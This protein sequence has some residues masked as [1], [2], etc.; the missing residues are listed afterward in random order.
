MDDPLEGVGKGPLSVKALARAFTDKIASPANTNSTQSLL[1]P[2]GSRD[3]STAARTVNTLNKSVESWKQGDVNSAT[4]PALP[5]S[6][7]T[8]TT[9]TTPSDF[10]DTTRKVSIVM[11]TVE[12]WG[13]DPTKVGG[14]AGP[15]PFHASHQHGSPKGASTTLTSAT[16]KLLHDSRGGTSNMATVDGGRSPPRINRVSPTP[17]FASGGGAGGGTGGVSDIQSTIQNMAIAGKAVDAWA[18][19]SSSSGPVSDHASTGLKRAT[20]VPRPPPPKPAALRPPPPPP[21]PHSNKEPLVSTTMSVSPTPAYTSELNSG[22]LGSRS[23]PSVRREPPKIPDHALKAKAK[24]VSEEPH[25]TSLETPNPSAPAAAPPPSNLPSSIDNPFSDDFHISNRSMREDSSAHEPQSTDVPRVDSVDPSNPFETYSPSDPPPITTPSAASVDQPRPINESH[26]TPM[27]RD[28]LQQRTSPKLIPTTSY[29]ST[30]GIPGRT[31]PEIGSRSPIRPPLPPRPTSPTTQSYSSNESSSP[32]SRDIPPPLPSRPSL[33][34]LLSEGRPNLPDRP[35]RTMSESYPGPHSSLLT[36]GLGKLRE[37][38]FVLDTFSK[39]NRRP[40][41]AEGIANWDILHKGG[42]VKCVAMSGFYFCTGGQQNVRVFYIPTGEN[43]RSIPLG[44]NKVTAMAFVPDR[45]IEDEGRVLWV[46]F[47]KGELMSMDISAGTVL[48]RRSAHNATVTHIIR[49]GGNLLTLDENGGFKIWYPDENGHISLSGPVRSL[50]IGSRQE[51][52]IVVNRK[53]WTA[54]GRMVEIYN[55]EETSSIFQQRIEIREAGQ[56]T[57]FAGSLDEKL[58]YSGHDDGK[59]IMWDANACVKMRVVNASIYKITAL[60]CTIQ[61]QVWVG[62]STGK[63][64]V[65]ETTPDKWT[66]LKDFTAHQATP[67]TDL[68]VDWKAL[69]STNHLSV[70]SLA[71][72]NGQMRLWDGFLEKD[73]RETYI[74]ERDSAFCNYRTLKVFV[75]SWNIDANK[76][77]ALDGRPEHEQVLQQWF[78]QMRNDE[79][80][81]IVIG[82]QELVDLESKKV[83]AKKML[84]QGTTKTIKGHKNNHAKSNAD[85]RF[86]AWKERL[87]RCVRELL[88]A[89]YRM[90]ECQQLV[91]LFQC[92][93]IQEKETLRL[94]AVSTHQVKT[95]LGGFH[96]NKG[97]VATR[98]ILEESSFC[99]VNCHLAAHQNEVSARN[100]DAVSIRD[101]LSF[102]P[103]ASELSF[104]PGG[105]GSLIL[106]HENVIISGDLNYRIDLPRHKVLEAIQQERY[107]Y[108][109]DYDQLIRQMTSNSLFG[110]RGFNEAPINFAPTFKYDPFT[111]SYDTSEKKRVPAY[112]DRILSRGNFVQ[113]SYERYE[114]TI[115]DHRPISATFDVQVKTVDFEKCEE[116]KLEADEAAKQYFESLVLNAKAVWLA[117]VCQC[118]VDKASQVLQSCGGD[119]RDA[120]NRL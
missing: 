9:T 79:P 73:W 52:A 10:R 59:V 25:I 114:C 98:F 116:V 7:M 103:I 11:K 22:S 43:I 88:G 112:C 75:G 87:T 2:V 84:F 66:V 74:R 6:A 15:Q 92:I 40:P 42:S 32:F 20:T 39:V 28:L 105:D 85:G 54:T 65:Y 68:I 110:F 113:T 46:A 60:L 83:N 82:F 58:L 29:Y 33:I 81:M 19:A 64:Y 100:N 13:A 3:L 108:L 41:E 8:P 76:P 86:T 106:D 21:P 94:R 95:G 72:D 102:A 77:E 48:E 55:P 63:I 97:A 16:P 1:H 70:V 24:P 57:C 36:S 37:A 69:F 45:H 117:A 12:A 53:L 50:R 104:V 23:K 14:G 111:T 118:A 67:V 99:F 101:K 34:P 18:D 61:N 115:S 4:P 80:E 47:E 38:P 109:M 119:L 44:D 31:S 49:E 78:T 71:G 56:V 17:P 27:Q 51:K 91:G 89:K 5:A 35:L 90:V 96:G 93:F 107:S 26:N 120:R 62:Y 30:H